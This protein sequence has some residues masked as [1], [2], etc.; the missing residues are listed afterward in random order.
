MNPSKFCHEIEAEQRKHQGKCIYHLSKSHTTADCSVKKEC[1][2]LVLDQKNGTSSSS[3]I[4]GSTGYLRHFTD[5]VF[6]DAAAE[7]TVDASTDDVSN[8]TNEEDLIYFARMTKH[9][10]HLVK[11]SSS[12]NVISR[13]DMQYPIIIN[14]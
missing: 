14:I 1:D 9:Y 12:Q 7:N 13:H 2:K 4:T 5:N 8:D 6:E 11:S 3:P 10:L